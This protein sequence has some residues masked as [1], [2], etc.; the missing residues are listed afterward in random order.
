MIWSFQF[1]LTVLRFMWRGSILWFDF[2]YIHMKYNWVLCLQAPLYPIRCNKHSC[3]GRCD[4]YSSC[5][6]KI[7]VCS[8]GR[9]QANLWMSFFWERRHSRMHSLQKMWPFWQ[10]KGSMNGFKQRQHASKGFIESLPSRSFCVPY[11]SLR[12]SSYVKKARSLLFFE[13]LCGIVWFCCL[14]GE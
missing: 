11:P 4:Q 8:H 5:T 6:R 13:C 12:F 3:I 10:H 2:H 9:R 14:I 7:E 1:P